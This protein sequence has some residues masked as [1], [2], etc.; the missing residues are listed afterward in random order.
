VSKTNNKNL[1]DL[2]KADTQQKILAFTNKE[3]I[4]PDALLSTLIDD[5]IERHRLLKISDELDKEG[6]KETAPSQKITK[7][8]KKHLLELNYESESSIIRKTIGSLYVD[9]LRQ[10][11]ISVNTRE[12]YIV[13]SRR[14]ETSRIAYYWYAGVLA[15]HTAM[16]FGAL[17]VYLWHELLHP[18][19]EVL[20]VGM[21]ANVEVCYQVFLHLYQLFEKI[22]TTYK[23]NAGNWGN[24]R[25][26]E[27]E[28]GNYMYKFVQ[29]LYHTHAYI[30]ND[31]CNKLL[32]D[33]ADKKFAYAM[34]D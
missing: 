11:I 19:S 7:I 4:S 33:Y 25:E 23:K 17:E 18:Y 21:P 1:I 20:F 29:E 32:Y 31:E 10:K 13:E 5:E 14:L 26:M 3:G 2:L 28:A 16:W 22:K 27:E 8:C 9:L 34:R 30:E 6:S 15:K 12:G 24:K